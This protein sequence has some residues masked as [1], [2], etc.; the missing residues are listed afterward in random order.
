MRSRLARTAILAASLF[1]AL[2]IAAPALADWSSSFDA[3]SLALSSASIDAPTG[4]GAAQGSCTRR[5]AAALTIVVGWTA[6]DSAEATGYSVLRATAKNGP[7]AVV[8]GVSGN[9]VVTWTDTTGQLAFSTTYYYEVEATVQSWTSAVST[10]AK[11]KT[12]G[13]NCR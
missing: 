4:T 12:Q 11:I 10:F 7:Y 8:G 5:D 6:T 9:T 2:L 1:P 13:M 3:G